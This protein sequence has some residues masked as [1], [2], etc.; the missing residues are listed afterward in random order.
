MLMPFEEG[1]VVK[2]GCIKASKVD[3]SKIDWSLELAKSVSGD[4]Q[5]LISNQ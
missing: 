3:G 5:S 2:R 4:K 1:Q